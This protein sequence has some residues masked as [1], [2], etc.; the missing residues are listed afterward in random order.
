MPCH[1]DASC[2]LG[3]TRVLKMLQCFNWWI[4]VGVVDRCGSRGLMWKSAQKGGRATTSNT[5][6]VRPF[7]KQFDGVLRTPLPKCPDIST[8]VDFFGLP[9]TTSRGNSYICLFTN[10]FNCTANNLVNRYTSLWGCPSTF[11]PI[12]ELNF[13]PSSKPLCMYKPL[14]IHKLTT[15]LPP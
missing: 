5:R 1:A 6:H 12:T 11:C 2:H 14:I 10:R 15:S 13:G 7:A 9:P 3:V 8:S 4:G